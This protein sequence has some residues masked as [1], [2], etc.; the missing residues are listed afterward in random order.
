MCNT[1]HHYLS[2]LGVIKVHF[3]SM[4]WSQMSSFCPCNAPTRFIYKKF[5][6]IH[7]TAKLSWMYYPPKKVVQLWMSTQQTLEFILLFSKIF[8]FF[9][10]HLTFSSSLHWLKR[11]VCHFCRLSQSSQW[12]QKVCF[13]DI[14]KWSNH[15]GGESVCLAQRWSLMGWYIKVLLYFLLERCW[16]HLR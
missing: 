5:L 14:V 12:K 10:C 7:C 8:L 6:I 3:D 15:C 9:C 2:V 1:L 13:D 16:K 4:S 11:T